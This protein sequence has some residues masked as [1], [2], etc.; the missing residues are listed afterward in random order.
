MTAIR[1]LLAT[2]G[3]VIWVTAPVSALEI[4][5]DFNGK[6]LKP[7]RWNTGELSHDAY[8]VRRTVQGNR[9]HLLLRAYADTTSTSGRN[10]VSNRILFPESVAA[11]LDAIRVFA[12][13]R[14]PKVVSCDQDTGTN[15]RVFLP[16]IAG[17][18]FNDGNGAADNHTGDMWASI[19][20][21]RDSG[22]GLA[23]DRIRFTTN[24]FHCSDSTCDNG[25]DLFF[26]TL[27]T[28][29]VKSNWKKFSLLVEHG[30]ANSQFVFRLNKRDEVLVPYTSTLNQGLPPAGHS[31]R[32][33]LRAQ[34][35]NCDLSIL[36]QKRP[37]GRGELQINRVSVNEEAIP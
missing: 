27:G 8:D 4:Y 29:K 15:T 1:H 7:S 26:D 17:F 6:R 11:N 20:A 24:V 30:E 14:R 36:D 18:W 9:L 23:A 33:E 13:A 35:E 25:T 32:I 2:V 31:M 10:F 22:D 34:V 19:T 21:R 3:L 37:E 12:R 28:V 16:R 5:D